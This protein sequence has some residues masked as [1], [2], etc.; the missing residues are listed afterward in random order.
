MTTKTEYFRPILFLLDQEKYL[1]NK[2]CNSEE[3]CKQLSDIYDRMIYDCDTMTNDKILR[4]RLKN[5]KNIFQKR[6]FTKKGNNMMRK[7]L[8][9]SRF[10]NPVLSDKEIEILQRQL[11]VEELD[12]V[13]NTNKKLLT[14]INKNLQSILKKD[15]N[16][17]SNRFQNSPNKPSSNTSSKNK[18]TKR[19]FT[20]KELE[21]SND[22]SIG[23]WMEELLRTPSRSKKE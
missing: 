23:A 19:S 17:I 5:K 9:K 8:R 13:K 11:S 12:E 7:T 10:P 22:I 3:S 16:Y 4:A 15:G 20:N 14:E 21:N 2:I 6:Y 1:E 18:K